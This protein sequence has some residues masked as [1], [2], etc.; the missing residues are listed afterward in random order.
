[1]KSRVQIFTYSKNK[2]K[3]FFH[4]KLIISYNVYVNKRR[5]VRCQG[6]MRNGWPI[7]ASSKIILWI[8]YLWP[9]LICSTLPSKLHA[10][11]WCF[12]RNC[13]HLKNK[14]QMTLNI[15][16]WV[17]M[18]F[19]GRDTKILTEHRFSFYLHS[20]CLAYLHMRRSVYFEWRDFSL[21]K[22][23]LQRDGNKW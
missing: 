12:D 9:H 5:S 18:F 20:H 6:L 4:H 16:H 17:A 19:D 23:V 2:N 14:R 11:N 22:I 1:M 8:I 15:E 21:V 10:P 13:S 7:V 3:N